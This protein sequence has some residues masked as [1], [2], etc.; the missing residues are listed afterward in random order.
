ML[1]ERFRKTQ[2]SE[3]NQLWLYKKDSKCKSQDQTPIS[4]QYHIFTVPLPS[5]V[6]KEAFQVQG[7][8]HTHI[9]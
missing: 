7:V 2:A 9:V 4:Q 8:D 1:K 6:P 5:F 3:I